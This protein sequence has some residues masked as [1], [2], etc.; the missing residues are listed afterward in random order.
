MESKRGK[1]KENRNNISRHSLMSVLA[2]PSVRG[3]IKLRSG[4]V[5]NG[6]EE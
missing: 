3:Q 2:V 4:C 6:S 5:T 1:R